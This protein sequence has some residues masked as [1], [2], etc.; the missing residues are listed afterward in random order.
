MHFFSNKSI[1]PKKPKKC[2]ER[3]KQKI[4]SEQ[5]AGLDKKR[6]MLEESD[7]TFLLDAT[8]IVSVGSIPKRSYKIS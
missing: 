5:I 7:I 1:E 2:L 4:K 3:L 8:V 6:L